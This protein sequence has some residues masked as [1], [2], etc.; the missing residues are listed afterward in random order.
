MQYAS[1]TIRRFVLHRVIALPPTTVPTT[2]VF[3]NLVRFPGSIF[4]G[5]GIRQYI[6]NFISK[7]VVDRRS[8]PLYHCQRNYYYGTVFSDSCLWL[9][10]MPPLIATEDSYEVYFSSFVWEH[11]IWSW[12]KF[13]YRC[14]LTLYI[15]QV[16]WQRY[17]R[18]YKDLFQSLHSIGVQEDHYRHYEVIMGDPTYLVVSN[19]LVSLVMM[20]DIMLAPDFIAWS[21]ERVTQFRDISS[22]SLGCFYSSRVEWIFFHAMLV[23]S[24]QGPR[25]GSEIQSRGP[26]HT[27]I[28]SLSLRWSNHE[29]KREHVADAVVSSFLGLLSPIKCLARSYRGILLGWI[30]LSLCP[31]LYSLAFHHLS[32]YFFRCL[33]RFSLNGFTT[34]FTTSISVQRQATTTRNI[35]GQRAFNDVMNRILFELIGRHA[36][37]P[38]RKIG[39]SLHNLYE[40]NPQYRKIPLF[41]CRA[42]DCFVLCYTS[43]TKARL[44]I[45]LSLV[46]GLDPKL[47]DPILAIQT[48]TSQHD[49]SFATC[50]GKK[51]S[52]FQPSSSGQVC[53]HAPGHNVKWVA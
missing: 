34:S 42:A 28:C 8:S 49:S 37:E 25:M 41:S 21:V 1:L 27:W 48:C 46:E 36:P 52:T 45:R 43:D 40:L 7:D 33:E 24:S 17:G 3:P 23:L 15:L 16:L 44:Q 38:A 6:T 9:E 4:Y 53:I 13:G 47:H 14:L 31:V 22:F 11:A 32:P 19:P 2:A 29:S 5:A 12:F 10:P 39:G 35:H 30:I 20:I 51:C 18:H 50:N 26:G